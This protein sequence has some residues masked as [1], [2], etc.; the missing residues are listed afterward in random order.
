MVWWHVTHC[1]LVKEAISKLKDVKIV[2]IC[3]NPCWIAEVWL[4]F[5]CPVYHLLSWLKDV[6]T[7]GI[8]SIPVELWKSLEHST[9]L[10]TWQ[11]A[12]SNLSE[13]RHQRLEKS[14]FSPD[15]ST[16][17][18]ILTFQ[19]IIGCCWEFSHKLLTAHSNVRKV[20]S[21][22]VCESA[23]MIMGF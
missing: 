19:T 20:F 3:S 21:S 16:V 6:K 18:F 13:M 2:G 22:M 5:A 12:H 4:C 8:C 23:W 9:A 14:G 15:N 17:D 7:V 10:Y 11:G 1:Q